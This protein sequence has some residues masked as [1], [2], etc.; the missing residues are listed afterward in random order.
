MGQITYQVIVLIASK[1]N[2][3]EKIKVIA[4]INQ[5]ENVG[6]LDNKVYI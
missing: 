4:S 1:K 6:R 3:K 5:Y 2:L